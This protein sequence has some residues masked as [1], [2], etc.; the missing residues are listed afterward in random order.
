MWGFQDKISPA[1]REGFSRKTLGISQRLPFLEIPLPY[2]KKIFLGFFKTLHNPTKKFP[3][4][5]T[6]W[7]EKTYAVLNEYRQ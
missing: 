6:H 1:Q 4:I 5:L 2:S 3:P 7:I